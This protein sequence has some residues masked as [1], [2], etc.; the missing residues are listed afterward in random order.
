MYYINEKKYLLRISG[1]RI[2]NEILNTIKKEIK[3]EPFPKEDFLNF[4]K[5]LELTKKIVAGS[6]I[7]ADIDEYRG[8]TRDCRFGALTAR[9][10]ASEYFE[11][12]RIFDRSS[13]GSPFV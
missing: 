13:E 2:L 8:R 3:I 10:E 6:A 12:P 9:R 11:R 4:I 1:E 7:Q 5:I